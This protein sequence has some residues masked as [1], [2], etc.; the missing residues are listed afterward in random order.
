MAHGYFQVTNDI[1]GYTKASVFN[2]LGKTTP[3]FTRFSTTI[4]EFSSQDCVRDG[5]GFATKFYTDQ[6][7]FDLTTISIDVFPIRDPIQF[8]DFIHANKNNP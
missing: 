8:Q 7:N 6:G 2:G 1:S 4:G 3:I 5:M